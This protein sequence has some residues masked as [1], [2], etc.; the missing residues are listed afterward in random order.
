M[1]SDVA[2]FV[3]AQL[4]EA[5]GDLVPAT[6]PSIE[7][8][9]KRGVQ[10]LH[11]ES[12]A[13]LRD[14]AVK[15]IPD[16][17][18]NVV[19]PL[20]D[21]L[22][23][24]HQE[25]VRDDTSQGGQPAKTA[26]W[27]TGED[28]PNRLRPAPN[29][30]LVDPVEDYPRVF[31]TYVKKTV[32]AKAPGSDLRDAAIQVL[33]GSDELTDSEQKLIDCKQAWVP[34][35]TGLHASAT[36]TPSRASFKFDLAAERLRGR[37]DAWVS[38]PSPPIGRYVHESLRNYLG[39]KADPDDLAAAR[40]ASRPRSSPRS[41]PRRR[42][43]TSTRASS[44]R[45]TTRTRSVRSASPAASP[46]RRTRVVATSSSGSWRAAAAGRPRWRRHCRTRADESIDFF[47]V[48][49]E[50]YEPVVFWSLMGPIASEWGARSQNPDTRQEFWRW[51]RARPLTEFVPVSPGIR[52]AM[53]RGWF[54]AS[55]MGQLRLD[56]PK[57]E[58]FVPGETGGP[59]R[60]M[61][62]PQPL[63]VDDISAQYEYLPVVLQSLPLA[64]VDVAVQASLD[65]TTPYR[66]LR[67]LGEAVAVGST[68]TRSSP[69]L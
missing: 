66:R 67:Q 1:S 10:C 44:S 42:W 34:M 17:A 12:E 39:D 9:V 59:G 20:R 50:P 18:K 21:A 56:G 46:S 54:T 35:Y 29:E 55:L 24:A 43:S 7:L 19:A 48:L 47:S 58:I 27:P 57:A 13:S 15:L 33:T 3:D 64:L 4:R 53:V 68:A 65:P 51:R 49:S 32:G 16:L 2:Q 8:A 30:F 40:P 69:R 28:V 22:S 61:S 41:T 52:K 6:H 23:E 45:F 11:Y 60:W 63:L 62:F 37:A 38:D 31:S 5:G 36:D 25:L 14:L 26:L